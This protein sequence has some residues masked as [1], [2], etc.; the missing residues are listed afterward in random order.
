VKV[1]KY[2]NGELNAEGYSCKKG[3]EYAIQEYIDPRRI[4]TTTMKV[5]NGVLPLIPVRSNL[6]IPKNKLIDCMNIIANK[7]AEAPI[8]MGNVLIPN[9][10]NLNIDIIASRDLENK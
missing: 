3:K 9:I 1:T 2:E 8:K 5:K 6:A 10:L 7:V 4:L